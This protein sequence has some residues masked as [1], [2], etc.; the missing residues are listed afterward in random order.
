MADVLPQRVV[1]ATDADF[2]SIIRPA[3]GQLVL[4]DF[5]A[6]WCGP[7][8]ALA[9]IIEQLA[10]DYE[11]RVTVAKLDL[12]ANPETAGM[13]GAASIPL[14]ILYRNGEEIARHVGGVPKSA[15]AAFIEQHR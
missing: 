9:P 12:T 11:G 6:P 5:W 7:C 10:S 13:I 8:V 3:D 2:A 1:L 15:L 4:V 14:L